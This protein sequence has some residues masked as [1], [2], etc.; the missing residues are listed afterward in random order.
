MVHDFF[1]KK[2]A[3]SIPVPLQDVRSQLASDFSDFR[4][5]YFYGSRDS[6]MPR[7]DSDYVIILVFDTIDYSKKLKIA[8]VIGAIEYEHAV[9]V[10]YKIFTTTGKRSTEY[11]RKNINP[12]FIQQSVDKGTFY[13]RCF[14][15]NQELS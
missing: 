5:L 7:E 11:I 10:D 13:G 15:N 3:G 2:N 14:H 4:G 1:M 8:G 9:T 12:F 6:G